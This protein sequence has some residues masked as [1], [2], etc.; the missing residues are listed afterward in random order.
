MTKVLNAVENGYATF[1]S[2]MAV[3]IVSDRKKIDGELK[4]ICALPYPNF[5]RNRTDE[6]KD[7]KCFRV[8][9]IGMEIRI[10]KIDGEFVI[11][12][13]INGEKKVCPIAIFPE[14]IKVGDCVEIR[15]I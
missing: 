3:G 10:V 15:I 5:E 12:K 11:V 9:R 8:R 14:T 4:L 13:L 6:E 1:I 7:R 2:G